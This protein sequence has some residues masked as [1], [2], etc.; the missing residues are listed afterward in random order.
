MQSE[1]MVDINEFLEAFS[2]K[3]N[4]GCIQLP[5]WTKG[6]GDSV[7]I[8]PYPLA[9]SMPP[10]NDLSAIPPPLRYE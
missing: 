1:V 7:V 8:T 5:S 9:L 2:I 3:G 4:G 10:Q 6:K